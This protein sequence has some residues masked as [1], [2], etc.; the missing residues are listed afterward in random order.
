MKWGDNYK[1][2]TPTFDPDSGMK[3]EFRGTKTD[4]IKPYHLFYLIKYPGL[5][6]GKIHIPVEDINAKV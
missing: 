3:L 1:V 5:L 4:C 2:E 6:L